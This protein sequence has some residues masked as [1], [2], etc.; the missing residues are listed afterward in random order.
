MVLYTCNPST[1]T[2]RW[3]GG[4]EGEKGRERERGVEGGREGRA[5][6][7]KSLSLLFSSRNEKDT[8]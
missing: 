2:V 8:V 7:Q 1:A 3:E 5:I 4:R 6:R